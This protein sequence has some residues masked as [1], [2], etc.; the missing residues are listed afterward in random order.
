MKAPDPTWVPIISAA[1][2]LIGVLV[3]GGG[4]WVAYNARR[5]PI[6]EEMHRRQMSVIDAL[7]EL[8]RHAYH[9]ALTVMFATHDERKRISLTIFEND[10]RWVA[11]II[12]HGHYLPNE[13]LI[14]LNKLRVAM[15]NTAFIPDQGIGPTNS[16]D[17][18]FRDVTT[19]LRA[20]IEVDAMSRELEELFGGRKRIHALT[21][22]D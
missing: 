21:P 9:D 15:L 11:M 16:V 6:R 1:T 20:T 2:G 5:N 10:E 18:A 13:L 12:E 17:D 14:A 7:M 22:P 19:K 3:G 4:L 8:I